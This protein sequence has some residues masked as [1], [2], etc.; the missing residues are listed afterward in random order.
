MKIV[1]AGSRDYPNLTQVKN[2]VLNLPI[3][4]T[5]I[6]GGTHGVDQ[7]A[8]DTALAT[9]L[10]VEIHKADWQTYGKRAG[11]IRNEEMVSRADKV[12]VFWD[13]VS[14]GSK[15]T[16]DLALKLKVNLEVFIQVKELV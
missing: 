15:H 5:V 3:G 2:Y 11:Y 6:S 7:A 4:T 14:P 12:V 8:E 10:A 16:I 1:I 13:G 9:G